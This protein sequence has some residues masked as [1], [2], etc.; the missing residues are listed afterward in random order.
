MNKSYFIQAFL[1]ILFAALF[2]I[3]FKDVLPKRIFPETSN[4]TEN[5]IVDS[6]ML[7]AI[8]DS[9]KV[10]EIEEQIPDTLTFAENGDYLGTFFKKLQELEESGKGSVRI[11]YF[12]DSMTDGDLIV[13]DLRQLFQDI[14]GGLGVGFVSITSESAATR[15]SVRHSYSNNWRTQSFVNVKNPKRPFGVSGRVS[16]VKDS[17][18]VAW[19]EYKASLQK[20]ITEIYSPVLFYGNSENKNASVEISYSG[21]TT[22][23]VKPLITGKKL[24][25][26]KLSDN[27]VKGL[28]I[29]F[30]GADSIP[31]YGINSSNGKGVH[32]DNF[33]SRGNSGLPLS[34]LNASL[35]QE[36][37]KHLGNYDLIVL[38]FGANVLN[39]GKLDY[40]WYAKG[41]S[42][43][44]NQI[45]ACFPKASVLIISS[46]DKS[47]KYETEM[48]TDLAVVPLVE[49]QQKYAE[50]TQ[51]GFI[52]L[53]E[54][55]GGK[56]SMVKW[57]GAEPSLA[58]KDYTHFNARG[59]KKVAQ[60]IYN[61]LMEKYQ[62][63]KEI[64]QSKNIKNEL[65]I[66]EFEEKIDTIKIRK[67]S[68]MLKDTIE[69]KAD[70][71]LVPEEKEIEIVE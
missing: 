33:S 20:H 18:G 22:K 1:I 66:E 39:Y 12:G 37:E 50:E 44:V 55:M 5:V 24:N 8:S 64:K 35:M 25:A 71:I 10:E 58:T 63:F 57:V 61:E 49:A 54:L 21:D 46:A 7:E 67:D 6:L 31:F 42:K 17:I 48:K 3:G 14:Y 27:N 9:E 41:M 30:I 52:N 56:G 43:V 68:I 13:Q 36:F 34:L 2:F 59:S 70:S 38:H 53:Y 16:F 4:L 19:L 45:K 40:S 15:G 11:G 69:I 47:T 28:K 51:S 23:V 62:H 60:L 32:I 29:R 65:V 26:L